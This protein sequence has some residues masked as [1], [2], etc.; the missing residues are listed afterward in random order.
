MNGIL[1]FADGS[2]FEGKA[3]GKYISVAGE[4]VF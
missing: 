2:E 4:V 1:T 3:F